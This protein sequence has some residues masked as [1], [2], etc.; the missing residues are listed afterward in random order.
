LNQLLLAVHLRACIQSPVFFPNMKV[1]LGRLESFQ[2]QHCCSSRSYCTCIFPV[3]QIQTSWWLTMKL[4]GLF[5][6][7]GNCQSTKIYHGSTVVGSVHL[8][9]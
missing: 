1:P 3:I 8:P 7:L 9:M 6:S 4:M 2:L 5:K